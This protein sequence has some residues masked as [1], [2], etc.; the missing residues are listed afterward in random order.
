[1]AKNRSDQLGFSLVELLI[2]V[3]VIG[4][5]AAIA[6][7]NLLASRRAANEGSAQ[8]SLRTIHTCE[9]TYRATSGSGN[10]GTLDDL[11]G[12]YLTDEVLASGTKSGYTFAANPV[13]GGIGAQFYATAVP[14]TTSGAGKSGTRRFA[15]GEDGVPKADLT[16]TV[17]ADRAEVQSMPAIGN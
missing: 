6:V 12:Q 5:I 17:P 16:L 15:I 1:M 7:P 14:A 3:V 2:V 8:A 4:I 13:T 9:A 11:K 10:Y